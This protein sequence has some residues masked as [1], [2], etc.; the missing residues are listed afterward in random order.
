[1]SGEALLFVDSSVWIDF[2]RGT[3]TPQTG[4]LLS[5]LA[6]IDPRSGVVRPPTIIVGDLVLFEVLRGVKDGRDHARVLRSLQAHAQADLG[7]PRIAVQAAVHYRHLRRLGI[8]VRK[9]VDCLIAAWCIANRVP[10]LHND[11]DFLPFI[12]HCGLISA[13]PEEFAGAEKP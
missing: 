13:L 9:T 12:R 11:R 2:L 8:S 4:V 6:A 10:L 1:M 7:G 5:A 3:E